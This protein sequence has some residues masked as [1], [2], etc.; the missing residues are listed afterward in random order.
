MAWRGS[1]G[2]LHRGP[3]RPRATHGDIVQL[4]RQGID[5]EELLRSARAVARYRGVDLKPIARHVAG[6]GEVAQARWA[7][8]RRK[9]RLEALSE[10]SLDEQLTLVASWLDP[11]FAL[12]T[13]STDLGL[14]YSRLMIQLVF[15]SEP[16]STLRSG[17]KGQTLR[18]GPAV[19]EPM[20]QRLSGRRSAGRLHRS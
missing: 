7:A 4:A 20:D 12:G 3:D 11:V 1:V 18:P 6:Y 14:N 10:A 16:R 19:V 17:S 9:E 2:C 13:A 8:W 15:V 5:P